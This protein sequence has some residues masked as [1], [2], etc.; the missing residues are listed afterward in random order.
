MNKE[1][2]STVQELTPKKG[3]NAGKK[4]YLVNGTHWV[5]SGPTNVDT[6]ICTEEVTKDGKTYTNVVGFSTDTRM[7]V[8]DKLSIIIS[9]PAEYSQ[10]LAHLLK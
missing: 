5:K 7:L 3:T 8:Q 9:N 2:I 4:M 1:L 10:A 6:H